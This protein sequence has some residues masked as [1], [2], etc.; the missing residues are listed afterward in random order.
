MGPPE[1]R[2]SEQRYAY[3]SL[4]RSRAAAA[5][6]SHAS[7]SF[8]ACGKSEADSTANTSSGLLARFSP[9]LES[10]VRRFKGRPHRAGPSCLLLAFGALCEQ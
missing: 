8:S 7:A 10:W 2:L 4:T 5:L 3:A 1:G 6:R 9:L